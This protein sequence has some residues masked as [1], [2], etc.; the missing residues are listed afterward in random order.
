MI[1]RRDGLWFID[2][3]EVDRADQTTIA[4]VLDLLS[5]LTIRD[6]ITPEE[7]K[8]EENLSEEQLGFTAEDSI[9]V[10][11]TRNN[12]DGNKG[13][14]GSGE[15]TMVSFGKVCWLYTRFAP[16]LAASTSGPTLPSALNVPA[17]VLNFP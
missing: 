4:A 3:P 2:K 13:A 15:K 1:T 11:L 8:S 9:R 5:H 10:S 7:I 17:T 12:E 16:T 14:S 6:R